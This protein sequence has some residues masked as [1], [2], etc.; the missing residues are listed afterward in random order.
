M[1]WNDWSFSSSSC[2][3]QVVT[4]T[5]RPSE[6]AIA[7]KNKLYDFLDKRR[8]LVYVLMLAAFTCSAYNSNNIDALATKAAVVITALAFCA[9]VFLEIEETNR[10][11]AKLW[12]SLQD[13]RNSSSP[14]WDGT[15][16]CIADLEPRLKLLQERMLQDQREIDH[17]LTVQKRI[18]EP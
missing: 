17:I 16:R 15:V 5:L 8:N 18:E 12:Q 6:P 13:Q 1:L 4:L 7:M 10:K 14:N 2:R 11:H 9:C 3:H